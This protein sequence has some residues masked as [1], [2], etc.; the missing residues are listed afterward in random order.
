MI[1]SIQFQSIKKSEVNQMDIALP[2]KDSGAIT[3]ICGRNHSGK[4]YLLRRTQRTIVM[5]NE[6]L[7][8]AKR[9]E[10]D[11]LNTD[12]IYCSFSPSNEPVAS[13]FISNILNIAK[14]TR[15][16]STIQESNHKN[17]RHFTQKSENFDQVQIKESLE[18]FAADCIEEYHKK[19]ELSFDPIKWKEPKNTE[20][21]SSILMQ[22]SRENLY[23]SSRSIEFLS[24]FEKLINGKLYFG[25]TAPT[26]SL[27]IFELYLVFSGDIII[28]LGSWS[29][30]QRVLFT[31]LVLLNYKKPD[32]LLID[33]IENHLHPEYISLVLNY[34]KQRIPQTIIST[35]HP[36]IIF[37]RYVDIVHF[38]EL[39][40][41]SA[42][43]PDIIEYHRQRSK[44]PTRNV[45]PLEKTY[46]KLIST[47]QLFDSYDNLLLRLSSSNLENLNEILINTFTS[48]FVYEVIPPT[49]GKQPDL[50]S[51][52]IYDLIAARMGTKKIMVLEIGAGDGRLLIDINKVLRVTEKEKIEW[53]LY[54]PSAIH[55]KNIADALASFPY[56]HL[57]KVTED[58]PEEKF[59]FIII[60]NVLHELVPSSI[61]QILTYCQ[62]ALQDDGKALIIELYPL[63][64]PEKYAVPLNS[65]EW[66][67]L[68][69]SL[70]FNATEE[71]I[72]FKNASIEAYFIE[73]TINSGKK[74][75]QSEMESLIRNFWDTEVIEDRIANYAGHINLDKSE[76]IPR[77]IGNLTTI[78]SILASK[79]G[80]W[81]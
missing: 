5:R 24:F 22:M 33:E 55:R 8:K 69:R 60:A 68:S 59:D 25:I 57:V 34:V 11:Q 28:P 2:A 9:K 21:R 41:S 51:Q 31:L 56:K 42:E 74:K 67:R 36:H 14:L 79:S 30:G 63:L 75:T 39:Q 46:S 13:V 27:P 1:T 12:D 43:T 7:K 70:G 80:H 19:Y 23:L 32:V 29:E 4:S 73:L 40:K 44:S 49:K 35:H 54:E 10:I 6:E 78:V 38:L 17:R 52:K 53:H 15:G 47:Y 77:T 26:K 64:K 16:T 20:Y 81:E 72:N 61:A 18:L 58:L 50:Q 37:S 48:L 45:Y 62:D 66:V 71:K 65:H 3:V 76:L